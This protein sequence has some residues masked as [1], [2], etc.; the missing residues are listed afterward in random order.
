MLLTKDLVDAHC[1]DPSV[2]AKFDVNGPNEIGPN[3]T[4]ACGSSPDVPPA[5][6]E[7]SLF[8]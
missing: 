6:V 2:G 8:F 7:E 4:L 5:K 3:P 1:E